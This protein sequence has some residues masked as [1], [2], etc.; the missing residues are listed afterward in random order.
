MYKFK[1]WTNKPITRGDCLKLTLIAIVCSLIEVAIAFGYVS[2]AYEK[3]VGLGAKLFHH[4]KKPE[5]DE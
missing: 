1:N 4:N 3:I 2:A 5:I